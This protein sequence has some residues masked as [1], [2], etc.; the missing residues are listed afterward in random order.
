MHEVGIARG[1]PGRALEPAQHQRQH[2]RPR[3]APAQ[4]SD[5]A[6]PVRDPVVLE[7]ERGD[8]LDVDPPA[9]DVLDRVGDEAAHD[10]VLRARP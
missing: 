9:A 1:P 3:R 7:V 10:I 8:D 5:H 6:G 4:I 2:E